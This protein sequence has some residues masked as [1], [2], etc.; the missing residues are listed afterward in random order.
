MNEVKSA[1]RK[2]FF[3]VLVEYC[4]ARFTGFNFR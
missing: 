1:D 2:W 3:Q 4:I